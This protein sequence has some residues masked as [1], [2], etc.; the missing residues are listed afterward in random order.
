MSDILFRTMAVLL[1]LVVALNI[2][3]LITTQPLPVAC[4]NGFVME[5]HK[6]MWVQRSLLPQ[7]CVVIDR[8]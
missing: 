3:V 5:Q 1:G 7:H 6:D 4:V 2:Y 8:D